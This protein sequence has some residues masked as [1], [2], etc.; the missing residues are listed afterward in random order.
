[1]G[2]LAELQQVVATLAV[3]VGELDPAVLSG[4]DAAGLV[5]VFAQAEKL[6][7]AGKAL[8]AR[9]MADTAVWRTAGDRSAAHWLA[10]RTGTSI[11]AAAATIETAERLDRLPATNDAFRAGRLSEVQ[12]REITSA[13]AGRPQAETELLAVAGRDG[14]HGLRDACRQAAAAGQPDEVAHHRAIHR[15]RY[16]RHWTDP[17]GAACLAV[18]LTGHDMA[19]VLTGIEAFE[20][21]IFEAARISGRK[22]PYHAYQA[23]ALVALA[24]AARPSPGPGPGPG[25]PAATV[26]VLIDHAALTRGHTTTGETCRIAGVGPIP[27]ATAQ[28]MMADAFLAAVVTDGVDVYT[29][30]HL[31]RTVTAHQRTALE[32]RDRHCVVPGC[33]VY[34]HL[35]IDHVDEWQATHVT[36]LDR[37]AR[38][39]HFHHHQKTYDGYQLDGAPGHWRWIGP[40]GAQIHP[41]PPP[42]QPPPPPPQPPPPPAQPPPPPAQQAPIDDSRNCSRGHD[43]T[44][45]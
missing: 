41:Q 3:A 2:L 15:G 26:H 16:L 8:A 25:R 42:P 17:D 1:M 44:P 32:V 34:R 24:R 11:G 39:C 14:V 5:E 31:G 10:R 13:A 36:K 22:E 4:P 28:A 45:P 7:G 23:D 9:R 29:V 33:P 21:D 35:E 38:L 6:C 12:A 27:V 40:D 18:R 20:P 30:A 19:Q 43:S 37:L